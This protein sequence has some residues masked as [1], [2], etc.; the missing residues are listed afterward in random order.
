MDGEKLMNQ[1]VRA[2]TKRR[3]VAGPDDTPG[4]VWRCLGVRAGGFLIRF[5]NSIL[6]NKTIM[7]W[8][9]E[10][11]WES[12]KK[13]AKCG[14]VNDPKFSTNVLHFVLLT[15]IIISSWRIIILQQ[16]VSEM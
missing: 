9:F 3:K 11:N 8:I 2:A 12:R 15:E 1:E 6:E 4:G 14:C 5:F 7:E 10:K 16:V 13:K